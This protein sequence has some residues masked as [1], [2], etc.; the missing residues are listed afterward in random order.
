MASNLNTLQKFLTALDHESLSKEDFTNAFKKVVDFVKKIEARNLQEISALKS[1][2]EQAKGTLKST[3][4]S[5]LSETQ[6]LMKQDFDKLFEEHSNSLN[7]IRD[8]VS[9]FESGRLTKDL[10]LVDEAVARALASSPEIEMPEKPQELYDSVEVL[11]GEIKQ[12]KDELEI[13]RKSKKLGGGGGTSSMG[14]KYALGKSVVK[15]TPTGTVNGTNKAYTLSRVPNS[16]LSLAI[17]GQVINDDEYTLAGK[18]I[19]M[20]SAIPADLSGTSFRVTY[21]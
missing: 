3:T 9:D 14:V 19:T 15:E 11:Q 21:L 6:Q 8:K 2:I 4:D 12:L 7:F 10:D 18:T 17:N 20:T 1:A 16:I 13:L 5:K